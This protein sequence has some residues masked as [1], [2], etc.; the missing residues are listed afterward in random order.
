MDTHDIDAVTKAQVLLEALPYVQRFRGATF[1][2]KY[3]GSFMDDPDPE[4]R[5][6]VVTDLVFLAAPDR[7]D[8]GTRPAHR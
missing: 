6:R 8:P 1:V 5:R 2:V 3:G 4:L 7:V